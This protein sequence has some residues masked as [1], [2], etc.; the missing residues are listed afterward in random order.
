MEQSCVIWHS[1]LTYQNIE[2]IERIQKCALRII[3]GKRY[4]SYEEAL[5]I[6]NLKT[7]KDRRKDLCE[8]FAK[9]CVES[10]NERVSSI[11]KVKQKFHAMETRKKSII[12]VRFA[13]TDRLKNSAITYMQR[14][15]NEEGQ[16]GYRI[17]K[18]YPT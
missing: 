18:K 17:M 1:S 2:D 4:K 15:L 9:N 6:L 12:D 5:D 7:L 8:R 10:P 11:F 3:L 14:M 13:K 16:N